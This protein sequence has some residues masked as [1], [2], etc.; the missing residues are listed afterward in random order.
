MQRF[1][2]GAVVAA[3]VATGL[4]LASAAVSAYWAFGGTALLDTV[5]GEIERWGRERS[6]SVL[7]TL[8]LIVILKVIGAGAPLVFV[9]GA[10]GY[11]PVWTRAP[12]VR[13]LGWIAAVGLTVYGCVLS[14]A[15][16]LVEAGVIDAADDADE[17]ALAWHAF[18]WDP[19]FALWGAAF[20][21]AMWRS[22]PHAST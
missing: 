14:V 8:W 9:G 11:L 6:T 13:G 21:L 7:V 10:A 2:H 19:W 5:G 1:D 12:R 15:G 22:R 20:A 3:S 18:F 17:H 4:G 16:L